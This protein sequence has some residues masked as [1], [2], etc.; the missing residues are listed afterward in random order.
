MTGQKRILLLITILATVAIVAVSAS[1]TILYNSAFEQQ[2]IRLTETVKSHAR[3]IEA[4]GKQAIHNTDHLQDENPDYCSFEATLSQFRDAHERC[5]DRIS[6]SE[7]V[8]ARLD[9]EQIDFL[10]KCTQHNMDWVKPIPLQSEMAEPMR[11]ALAGQ[12][13]TTIGLDYHGDMVVAAYEPVEVFGLGIVVKINLAEI[14]APFVRAGLISGGLA[15]VFIFIGVFLFFRIGNPMVLDLTN[16]EAQLKDITSNIPG[17][18]Y[19]YVLNKDGVISIPYMSRAIENMIGIKADIFMRDANKIYDFIH[20]DDHSG[21]RDSLKQSAQSMTPWDHDFR[22]I[23]PDKR[24]LWIKGNSNPNLR[25]N[26]SILWNGVLTDITEQ[27][28]AEDTLRRSEER[29]NALFEHMGSG[30][31]VY[32]AVNNAEDFVFRAY[33]SAAE[34]ITRISRQEAIGNRLLKLF[35]RMDK[36]GLLGALQRVWRTGQ[37]EHLPPF[38]YKDSLRE[39]W[40]ENRIYK[41]PS[42][43]V[44]AL[45][46]DITDR[47]QAE[48]ALKQSEERFKKLSNLTFEGILIHNN[49]VAIDVNESLTRLFGYTREEMIGVNII[50]LCIPP[51]FHATIKEN[52]TKKHAKPYEVMARKKDGTLLPIEIEARN[53]KDK[54]EEFRVTAIRDI[55]ERKQTEVELR[56]SEKRYHRITDAVTDYIYTVRVEDGQPV[57]TIHGHACEAVTGYSSEEFRND[58]YLWIQMISQKDR[59]PV[60]DQVSQILSGDAPE[61]I[62]HRLMRKD[63]CVRWVTSFLVAHRDGRGNLLSYEGL[64]HDI[65][66]RKQAEEKLKKQQYYLTKAQEIGNIGTWE[67]DLIKSKLIWT[68][69]N[70]RIFGVPLGT[71]LNY[72]IFL[73]QIHSDDKEYVNR[74]WKAAIDG[75]PYD[76]EHRLLVDDKIKWVREKADIQL[77]EDGQAVS[78]IG[79]TQDITERKLAEKE[80]QDSE[81]KYKHLFEK[82]IDG[83]ALHEII[84]DDSGKPIDYRFL[85]INP[86]FERLTGLRASDIIGKKV[87]EVMPD[88]EPIWVEKYGS[89]ALTGEPINFEEYNAALGKHFDITAYRPAEGQFACLFVDITER[90]QAEEELQASEQRYRDIAENMFDVVFVSNL[91]GIITY[92]SPSVKDHFG[93]SPEELIGRNPQ[94][95]TPENEWP[96]LSA[97]FKNTFE[98]MEVVDKSIHLI[99]KDGTLADIEINAIPIIRNGF[100]IGGQAII[101]D[102]TETKRLQELESRAERLETAGTIAGQ[103]AH[104]FNNL[105]AP[106]IAYPDFIRDDLPKNHPTLKY[107]DQMEKAAEKI[108]DINLQLLTLGRRGHYNQDILNLNTIIQQA[109]T[110]LEPMPKTLAYELDLCEDLLDICGGGAQLHRMINNMLNN[111]QDAMQ[112]IGQISVKTENYYVDDVSVV[113]GRVPKGEYVKLTITDTGCGIPDD[114]IQK[115]FDPFFSSK[116]TDKKRGSGLGMSVVDAVIKDHKGY[117]D[118]T[119]KVGEGTSFYIYFPITR[120]SRDE[121]Q[122]IDIYGGNESVLIIDDDEIQRQV[123]SQILKKLGYQITTV[124]SGEKAIELI[125]SKPFDLLVLDMI[126]PNGMDGAETYS[127]ILE[128]SPNQ[129]AIVVSGFSESERVIEAQKLGVGVFV[130]KPL[131]TESFASAVRNELDRKKEIA[132]Y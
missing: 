75:K 105:L 99:K 20:P 101:R 62:E 70:Y 47:K 30:A 3:L 25:P 111:S 125:R 33:N 64:I 54:G 82:M 40:R 67:L 39:G 45:F 103:V 69:E 115:I 71:E 12:S 81:K 94:Y 92:V 38:F 74:E 56:E 60:R 2:K 65:T 28:G 113:Y 52:I 49:G 86:S 79:F 26:G 100:I 61:P 84:C 85:T 73:E 97:M 68:D 46:D 5:Y 21:F 16:K 17:V 116:T 110:E 44:V 32:E 98:K 129:K 127:R 9:G 57:E 77:D 126:M 130:Q 29:F 53:I 7:I 37:P 23:I 112:N 87:L 34:R 117:I 59:D 13:G 83:F 27:K 8:L 35:P 55:T 6:T 119:T 124:D 122:D 51:E 36:S 63:G 24:I 108:A 109:V 96:L 22:V 106:L 11:L 89:V 14:R 120:K 43:E 41:L 104:D 19:Q 10:V 4:I 48:E 72:E 118:L 128:I 123:S 90:K 102:V 132:I 42:G 66:E 107:L 91:D 78:A 80:L 88:L 76:I 31:A 121:K 93:Y 131:T 15:I 58:P 18:V 114:I 50:E 1:F 95:I